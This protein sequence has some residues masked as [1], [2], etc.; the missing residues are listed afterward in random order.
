VEAWSILLDTDGLFGIGV[1]PNATA[2]NPGFEIDITMIKNSNKGVYVYNIDGI[3][4]CPTPILSYPL[5]TH[6]Q[7]AIADEVSCGSPDYFYDFYVP[8]ADIAAALNINVNTGLRFAALSNVSATCAMSGKISDVSGVDD[9]K[10]NH[11]APCMFNDLVNSQ[12]PT[13]ILDLCET[14]PGFQKD[15]VSRPTI[16]QPLVAGQRIISGTTVEQNI[17]VLVQVFTNIGTSTS[18]AWDTLS[19]PRIQKGVY[20]VGQIWTDTLPEPLLGYD[21]VKAIAKKTATS[22]PCGTGGGNQSSATSVTSNPLP[23]PVAQN[24][25]VATNEDTPLDIILGAVDPA[26]FILGYS[27]VTSP[28]HGTLTAVNPTTHKVTYVPSFHY[29]GPDVFTFMVTDGTTY[30]STGTISITVNPVNHAPVANAQSVTTPESTAAIITL[31]ATDV[32]GDALTYSIV[33]QPTNGTVVLVGAVATYTPTGY[34][35]GQDNFTFKANDGTVDSN[36]ATVSITVT[37]V[38]HAPVA[39]DQSV[40]T[41]ENTPLPISVTATDVDGNALTYTIVASPSHGT[42]SGTAPNVTYVPTTNYFGSDSF[43]FKA[44]DGTVDSNIGTISITV[45]AV[46]NAPVANNQSV[47]TPEDTPIGIVLTGSDVDGNGLTYS[48]GTLP[49]H[50]TLTGTAP[51]VTYTPTALYY[52]QDNFTFTVNDGTGAANSNSNVATVTI[53]V[54]QVN[55]TPVANAQTV[56]TPEDTPLAITLTGSDVD[57]NGLT[58]SIASPPSNGTLTGTAPNVTYTPNAHYVGSD[59]FT[60]TVDDGTGSGN[61]TSSPATVSITVTPVN[62]AP[63]A[64]NQSDNYTMNTAL[65][66]TLTGSDPDGNS[67]SFMIVSNP[68]NG[69]LT[70]TA[71]N[72]TYT[73][74]NGFTGSDSFT[75][76]VS[77]GSLLSNIATVFLALTPSSNVQPVA[78]PQTVTVTEDIP[79]LIVL[80]AT[81]A[82]ADPLTYSPTTPAHGTLSGTGPNVTYTPDA[83]YSGPDSF[84]FTVDDGTGTGNSTSVPATV[85]INVTPV[86]HAPIANNQ[87]VSLAENAS[88]AI[89]L[90]GS[91]VDGNSLTYS[92][93]TSPQHGVLTGSAPNVT[94]TPSTNYF[95]TDSFTFTVDD[96]TGTTNSGSAAATVSISVTAVNQIPVANSQLT[97]VTLPENTNT[98][99]TL[100]GSDADGDALTYILVTQP[101]HG[102][103]TGTAPN[104]IYTPDLYY[105]G[106]D[107]FTFKVNDGTVD[108]NIATVDIV[109]T[110]VNQV[111]IA[112]NQSVTLAE[113][114]STAITLTA[115]DVDNDA[116]TYTVVSQPSHGTL[117][118]TVP[119]L[120]YTPTTYYNG[121]DSFTFKANDGTVDSNVATVSI[122]ITPVN[123]A[124]VAV[125]QTTGVTVVENSA[126]SITLVGTD[127]DGNSLTYIIVTQPVNGTLSGTAPNITYTPTAGY[128]GK[129]SLTFKVNDGTVDSNIAT[130]IITVTPL[131]NAPVADDQNVTTPEDVPVAI[132]L[133]S[134]DKDGDPRTYSIVTNPKHGTLTGSAP[135]LTYTPT[136]YYRGTDTLTFKANDGQLDS[137][138]GTVSVTMTPVNHAPTISFIPDL[139]TKEDSARLVCLNV[140][141]VDGNPVA[142]GTPS[143][144]KGGGTMTNAPAPYDFCYLFTPALNYNG[145]STWDL[146]VCDNGGLC[147]ST[148]VKI[149]IIPVNDP[150]YAENDYVEV[151]SRTATSFNVMANDFDIAPPYKEF[152]D[153]YANNPAYTDP[154]TMNT[155]PLNG[156]FHGIVQ[157]SSD[158]TVSYTPTF[159]YVGPDSLRYQIC[160]SGNLCA[161]AV[162]FITVGYPP[163]KIYEGVSPNGDD[164]ND[165]WRIDGIEQ[166]PNNLV[167]IFDR[168][169]NLVYEADAYSNE[170]NNWQGQANHGLVRGT[171]PEGTYFYTVD[172]GDGKHPLSGFV[173]LKRH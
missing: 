153:I 79:K 56:S 94:Y 4:S 97:G 78:Y 126:V 132:T 92:I 93:G 111:P 75:F 61:S 84:S 114:G 33:G 14:C 118:G 90:T 51:N 122:T 39:N 158:G 7:I 99:I 115:S 37:P 43:T 28:A 149:I 163:F 1:D 12:C 36:I 81:D 137:N 135:N 57:G 21:K 49:S 22:V 150:P 9:T 31:T 119:N 146:N 67:I 161:T 83:N 35:F 154:I 16:N 74:N 105:N 6:F 125:S 116:L 76:Q 85:T 2:N 129:D 103:L 106:N 113:D 142:L 8:F 100:T 86:N 141:D 19:A 121:S 136:L 65:P 96:G 145:E 144:T 110:P 147:G 151:N 45:T 42:L 152:Y 130:V 40:T 66:I 26:N 98:T 120:T 170:K 140:V 32:D 71:P 47:T 38:N 50:G 44:N 165:Y 131:D 117:T 63:I 10:F 11:C 159:D 58:Y 54:T 162:A 156:P 27:I 73:P 68:S 91:D 134:S 148:S 52:G 95:G 23:F 17:Y 13:P 34:F 87:N 25:S 80:V 124:P 139:Y 171:L 72:V 18:P 24:Q 29:H 60:F 138:I 164:V 55:H 157:M 166:Y 128:S 77:D 173:Q 101:S 30:Q 69:T 82:N 169:N 143:N 5:D 168:Y 108:S 167:R 89:V 109:V 107:S 104:L 3:E 102:T 59:S 133:T 41:P 62:H 20:S 88:L 112:D 172:L 64:D 160:D 155:T 48:I 53:K 70:G 123:H 46:N 15:K 127:V